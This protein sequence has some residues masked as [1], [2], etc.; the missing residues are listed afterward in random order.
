PGSPGRHDTRHKRTDR[1]NGAMTDL[2]VV[3]SDGGD[4]ILEE[5][6][7]QHFSAG[8]RGPLLRSEDSGYDQARKVWNGMIDRRPALIARCGG[9]ADVLT[10]VRFARTNGVLV[11]VK[12]GGHNIT[13][14]AVC[15]G[16]LMIDLSP[17]KSV[18]V[19][20][21]RRTARASAGLTW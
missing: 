5:A 8:L 13:G 6:A 12:G 10:A 7:V 1:E 18:R 21:V 16:G 4:A 2:H 14:N 9:V 15:E 17:M 11:S 3:T 20:P 19:D